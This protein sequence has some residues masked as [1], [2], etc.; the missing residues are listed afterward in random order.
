MFGMPVAIASEAWQT[1]A[2]LSVQC[3]QL[4]Y[5]YLE[6]NNFLF[7]VV[8][9]GIAFPSVSVAIAIPVNVCRSGLW[10]H[11]NFNLLTEA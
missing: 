3:L 6:L 1:F 2:A 9:N 11:L 4:A 8:C 5:C 7:A 10:H